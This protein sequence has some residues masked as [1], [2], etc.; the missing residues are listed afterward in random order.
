MSRQNIAGVSRRQ[1]KVYVKGPYKRQSLADRFWKKVDKNGPIPE[2][3]PELGPC[4]IWTGAVYRGKWPYG[5]I[6]EGG[7]NGQVLP[8]HRVAWQLEH[9]PIEIGVLV[10][11]KCDQARCVRVAHLFLGDYVDNAR[12]MVNKGRD[13]HGD[14]RGEKNGS[15]VLTE[16][17]VRHIRDLH[18]QGFGPLRIARRLNLSLATVAHVVYR[19]TWSHIP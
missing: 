8:A 9:G 13:A 16:Q 2:H 11:H 5:K 18:S 12:D 14:T 17:I 15:A 3:C 19:H 1:Q 6:A 4:W 7:K 10:C